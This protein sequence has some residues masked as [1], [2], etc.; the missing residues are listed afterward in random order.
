MQLG[1]PVIDPKEPPYEPIP[2]VDVEEEEEEEEYCDNCG[3]EYPV[4]VCLCDGCV[5]EYED[6][7]EEE[8]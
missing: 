2:V 3:S 1:D 7:E 8:D 4:E 5:E 6:E